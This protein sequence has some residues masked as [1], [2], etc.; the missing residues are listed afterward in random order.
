[1]NG[2]AIAMANS[3]V[4]GFFSNRFGEQVGRIVEQHAV[5][6]AVAATASIFPGAG[7]TVAVVAQ[8]AAVYTMYVR[9]NRA[10]G[11]SLSKNKL[12]SLATAVVSNIAANAASYIAGIVIATGLSFIPGVGSAAS[13]MIIAGLGYATMVVAALSYSSILNAIGTRN[14]AVLSEDE[15][16]EIARD[17]MSKRDI[18]GEMK[19]FS[20]A[21]KRA[22]KS[23]VYTG[24]ETVTMEE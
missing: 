18:S 3:K 13:A 11:V 2:R 14:I 4:T 21:Y 15:L 16:R 9:I 23:G 8:T 12:K 19:E 22:R 10:L 17:E 7:P 1:M 5:A 6:S 24:N 20:A